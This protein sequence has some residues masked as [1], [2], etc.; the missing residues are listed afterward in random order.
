MRTFDPTVHNMI[1]NHPDVVRS[2]EWNPEDHPETNGWLLFG[3]LTEDPAS[4]WLLHNE[5]QTLAMI[6][7]WSAPFTVQMHT[8]SLPGSRGKAMMQDAKT[9]IREMFVDHE[10]EVIWG[11]T[12]LHNRRARMFNR[13]V[14]AKSCGFGQHHVAGEVE[15]FRNNRDDWLRDHG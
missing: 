6:F 4:Y 8:M 13:L 2:L 5:P 10:A 9:L 15:Y 12:P 1:G 3:N 7:E 11:M 14:G